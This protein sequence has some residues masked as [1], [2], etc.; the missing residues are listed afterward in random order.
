[1]DLRQPSLKSF[2]RRQFDFRRFSLRTQ[3]GL[4]AGLVLSLTLLA[5]ATLLFFAAR[6]ELKQSLSGQL[7]VLVSRVATELDD[8]VHMRVIALEAMAARF[9]PQALASERDIE[10]HLRGSALLDTLVDDLYLF[11]DKGVLR[12]D[13]PVAPGR[14]GL[15]MAARD[16]IKGV[17]DSGKTT[18][19]RPI[20]GKATRQPIIVIA[21]PIRAAD[22]R[23]TAILGG[24][25]NLQKSRLL[26][27]LSSTRVGRAGY[28]YLVGPDRLTITHPERA[29]ILRRIAEPGVDPMLDRALGERFEGTLEGVN[30]AGLK[31][32]FSFRQMPYTGWVLAGV[33]PSSE[34]WAAVRKL[35]WR[36]TLLTVAS[37]LLAIG[38]I[39]LIVRRFT[40]PLEMLTGFLRATRTLIPPPALVHSC[41]E[42]DRLSEAFSQFVEQQKLTQEKLSQAN[43]R[44][45][46]ANADL[47][48]AAIAFESQE[49]MFIANA[50]KVILRINRAFTAITGY[51][52]SEAV[53]CTPD[54]L[55]SGRHDA[56]F[57][58][59]MHDSLARSRSWRGEIWNRRK[60]GEIYPE[61]LTITG[62]TDGDGALT[63]YVATL[64][65]ISARK[66]AEE[67]IETLAFYD[68]LTHLP[69]RRLLLDRLHQALASSARSE[70]TG[71]LLFID[72]DNFKMLNDTLGHDKGDL[73]LQQVARRLGR[74]T[75]EGD[76]IARLG[77]DE[78]LLVLGDLSENAGDAAIQAEI[79]GEKILVALNL[80]YDLAG[81]E[82]HS[83][84]SIGATLFEGHVRSVDELMKHADLAMYE[85]KK[86]GRNRLRFFNPA[87]QSSIT[88]RAALER[89]L[90]EGLQQGQFLLHYQ[91]QVDSTGRVTGTEALVRWRHPQRGLVSP[92]V[93]I[94]LAEET[95]LIL[96]MGLWVL[97]MACKQLVAWSARP[98][99][100]HLGV[101]VNV[102]VVQFHRPDFVEQVLDV[103]D[104]SGANPHRLKLEL[105]ESLLL[106]NVEE[107][108]AK[109]L[110]LKTR[111]IGFSLDDFGTGYSSLSYLKRLPL[112]QLKIDQSFVRDLLTDPN[113]V[114]IARTIVALA[115]SLGLAV[116]AEGV[117]TAAQRDCL[118]L[119]GCH[120]YQG[121]LFGRPL[122]VTDF[123]QLVL[124]QPAAA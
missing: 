117:E 110:V 69:N 71:A 48:I 22:G 118:A 65:D 26:E 3:I 6:A 115:R 31:G 83:T 108:I 73:L 94:P 123:E 52:E 36:A 116:I 23:L 7:E 98:E 14:R 11:S 16:Y 17:L 85:A 104:R 124:A 103:L 4:A 43:L 53:G 113:D 21:V 8:K 44:A 38:V 62:V 89:D 20:L 34:A 45:E 33:Q 37:L 122:A 42:T 10:R 81:H 91:P 66:A 28:L 46:A 109:M 54:M 80:P 90:R 101:A 60:N 95:G 114:A 1:L 99:L 29:R 74:C 57:Y 13:F 51:G 82:Y 120:A 24:V 39:A 32:L 84:A 64:T 77:G 63:H 76:S 79:I 107:I 97:E 100:A 112:D 5:Q 12:V 72:L 68:P 58:A 30:S 59:Q 86:T 55:R 47:R 56:K 41:V 35:A 105:T 67:Q 18:I 2:I 49:G 87:M 119:Q 88:T 92:A 9:P 19:S 25:V 96:P 106:D 40:R 102:S 75:R 111:G 50:D 121:Y 61:W 70:R 27:P 78:F 93:F 15:D